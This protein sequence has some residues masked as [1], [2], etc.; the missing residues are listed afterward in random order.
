LNPTPFSGGQSFD[1]APTLL[2]PGNPNWAEPLFLCVLKHNILS[3]PWPP[4]SKGRGQSGSISRTANPLLK[5]NT[6]YPLLMRPK[7]L[8][9]WLHGICFL[10]T[11]KQNKFFLFYLVSKLCKEAKGG[12]CRVFNLWRFS[13]NIEFNPCS[14]AS[15]NFGLIRAWKILLTSLKI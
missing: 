12:L 13:Y 3:F 5:I 9:N 11:Q 15:P 4:L 2:W 10:Q 8:R 1:S 6:A 7:R 14:T